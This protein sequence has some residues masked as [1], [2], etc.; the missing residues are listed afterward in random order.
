MKER[1]EC[2]F[3]LRVRGVKIGSVSKWM[4]SVEGSW[5]KIE[6]IEDFDSSGVIGSAEVGRV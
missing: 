6:W 5:D 3:Y 4:A 1:V 2:E